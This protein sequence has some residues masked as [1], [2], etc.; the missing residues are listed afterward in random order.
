MNFQ[1]STL[2]VDH[3]RDHTK[4]KGVSLYQLNPCAVWLPNAVRSGHWEELL[5]M[6]HAIAESSCKCVCFQRHTAFGAS[7]ERVFGWRSESSFFRALVLSLAQ[8]PPGCAR[9]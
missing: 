6:L 3:L 5:S 8:R 7:A 2:A 9:G 4:E 1:V